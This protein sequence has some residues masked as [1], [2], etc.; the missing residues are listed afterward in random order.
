MRCCVA[1]CHARARCTSVSSSRVPMAEWV[2]RWKPCWVL[3]DR[4]QRLCPQVWAT[5]GHLIGTEILMQAVG[6]PDAFTWKLSGTEGTSTFWENRRYHCLSRSVGAILFTQNSSVPFQNV[7]NCRFP[8][9][10]SYQVM[11]KTFPSSETVLLR[12]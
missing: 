7:W 8:K 11:R 6:E 4:E 2:R 1:T 10:R 9:K 12:G 5:L 3:I